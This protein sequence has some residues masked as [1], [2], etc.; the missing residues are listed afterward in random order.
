MQRGIV[1]F[2][3]SGDCGVKRLSDDKKA[4]ITVNTHTEIISVQTY[5]V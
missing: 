1:G 4:P 2:T 3:K 5:S